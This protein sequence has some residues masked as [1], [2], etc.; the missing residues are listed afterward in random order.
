MDVDEGCF[1]LKGLKNL[2]TLVNNISIF[3]PVSAHL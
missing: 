2:V 1:F 3:V